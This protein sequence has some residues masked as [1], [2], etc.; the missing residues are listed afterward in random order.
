M[1][2]LWTRPRRGSPPRCGNNAAPQAPQR[3]QQHAEAE[4]KNK[5]KMMMMMKK[6]NNDKCKINNR[7]HYYCYR[8]FYYCYSYCYCSSSPQKNKISWCISSRPP[9]S[10]KHNGLTFL[11][12]WWS[13]P[14]T[15]THRLGRTGGRAGERA[16]GGADG[17]TDG[18]AARRTGGR[19]NNLK[20]NY[21]IA[22][23][24]TASLDFN[25]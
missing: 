4:K 10:P 12:S 18:W 20:L 3:C 23:T 25:W 17:R 9:S 21:V 2:C 22:W 7:C 15:S 1:R 11:A 6:N 16:G 5:T 19:E 14:K 24:S 8:S 13:W